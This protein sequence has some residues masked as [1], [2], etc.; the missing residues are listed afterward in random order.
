MQHV[1]NYYREEVNTI[2]GIVV[3]EGPVSPKTL[4]QYNFD[5]D[6][7][8]F[9]PPEQQKRALIEIAGLD[10]GRIIIAR[11]ES[12]TIGYVT[13]L[14]PDPLERWSEDKIENMLELGAIEVAP[15]YRGTGVGKKLLEVSFMDHEM[16]KYLIPRPGR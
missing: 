11:N 16:E 15:A 12:T 3:V 2:H 6:L 8:A 5:E 9:R 14:Y 7:V 1:K 4:E 13:F 10:E